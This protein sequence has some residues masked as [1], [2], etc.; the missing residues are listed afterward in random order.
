MGAENRRL[1]LGR[2]R[3]RSPL[4][5]ARRRPFWELPWFTR[6]Y[7]I[8]LLTGWAAVITFFLLWNLVWATP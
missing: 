8:G 7:R 2:R 4:G 5:R 1:D 6:V 3:R